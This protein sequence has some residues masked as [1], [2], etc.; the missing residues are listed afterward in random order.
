MLLAL[1]LQ[2]FLKVLF[3]AAYVRDNM[4]VPILYLSIILPM[5]TGVQR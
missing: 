5:Y 4:A 1:Q 2:P 3:R